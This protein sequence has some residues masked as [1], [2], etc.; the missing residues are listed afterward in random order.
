MRSAMLPADAH[1]VHTSLTPFAPPNQPYGAPGTAWAG[2]QCIRYSLPAARDRG[3]EQH[4]ATPWAGGPTRAIGPYLS[5]VR[6]LWRRGR[7]LLVASKVTGNLRQ[8]GFMNL[9][10]L[11]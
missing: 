11:H 6:K 7:L 4:S 8:I 3:P 2:A 10:H 1:G 9:T 5:A